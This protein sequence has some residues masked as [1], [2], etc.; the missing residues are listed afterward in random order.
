MKKTKVSVGIIVLLTLVFV[1]VPS[2]AQQ[3]LKIG[4]FNPL[5]GP[6][7]SWGVNVDRVTDMC[8]EEWNKKGGVTV[9]GQKYKIELIHEDDKY[10][11]EEGVK[12]INKLIFTDKV[13]FIVGPLAGSSVLA[14]QPISEANKIIMFC[15]PYLGPE[16]FK[17]KL[18]TFRV[19]VPLFH[20]SLPFFKFLTKRFPE[21][22]T[23]V[24]LAPNHA[25]GW[26]CTQA[27]NDAWDALGFKVLA[28]EFF[29]PTTQD[30]TA[31]ITRLLALKPD[32]ISLGGTSGGNAA[33][34]IK[35]TRELGYKGKIV[36]AGIFA[37]TEVG[38]IAGWENIEGMVCATFS[39]E[40]PACPPRV[41]ELGARFVEKYKDEGGF[42][43]GG[44]TF[45]A[46]NLLLWGMEKANSLDSE[47]VLKGIENLGEIN[48]ITGKAHLG[49]QEFYGI[50]RQ[51]FS[52]FMISEIRNRRLITV[53]LEMPLEV[54][55]PEKKWR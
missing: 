18:Y 33:M 51:L 48:S 9:K 41:K 13:K 37:Y 44:N 34:I 53:G 21:L 16:I 3:V 42:S 55:P 8:A 2:F 27:D 12:A 1:S 23:S 15:N 5:T 28:T 36:H 19:S 22:K 39:I 7:A 49:G 52:P 46:L 35:Q 14:T 32:F 29:E 25:S 38:S 40:G 26:A 47:Q 43:Q 17:N 31:Q 11:G 54:P 4:S 30:F 45:D 20:T 50:K 10:R 24:H 6:A